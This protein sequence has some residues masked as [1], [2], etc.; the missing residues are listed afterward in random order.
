MRSA[1]GALED[2]FY[3]A[4]RR[5]LWDA[6]LIQLPTLVIASERDF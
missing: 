4:I 3:Q 6:S 2:S 1:N 5:Q